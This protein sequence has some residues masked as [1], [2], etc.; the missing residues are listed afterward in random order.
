MDLLQQVLEHWEW[1][2]V[3]TVFLFTGIGCTYISFKGSLFG[4]GGAIDVLG[5]AFSIVL[6]LLSIIISPFIALC[7]VITESD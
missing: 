6:I 3:L 2:V 7:A 5:V 4:K 1:L